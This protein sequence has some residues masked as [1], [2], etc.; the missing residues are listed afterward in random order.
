[1][2]CARQNIV[3]MIQRDGP[4]C[5]VFIKSVEIQYARDILQTTQDRAEYKHANGEVSIVR[6]EM[7][8][9]ETKRVR[10]AN[11]PPRNT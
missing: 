10:I 4:R 8:G 6:I 2:F 9:R 1:M 7:A 5:Q 11:L 3:S